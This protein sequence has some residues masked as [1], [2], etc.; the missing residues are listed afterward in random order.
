MLRRLFFVFGS[1]K[2]NPPPFLTTT[3]RRTDKIFF[4]NQCLSIANQ[5]ILPGAYLFRLPEEKQCKVFIIFCR[6]KKFWFLSAKIFH[7][8]FFPVCGSSQSSQGF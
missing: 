7:F 6:F 4:Q 8:K 3:A 1:V 2:I 5:D